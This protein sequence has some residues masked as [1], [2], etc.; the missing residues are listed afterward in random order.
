[1]AENDLW[2]ITDSSIWVL[3]LS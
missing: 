1:M 3:C 2:V